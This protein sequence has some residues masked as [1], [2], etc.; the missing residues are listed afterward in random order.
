MGSIPMAQPAMNTLIKFGDGGSPEL[1]NI[2]ANV[3]DITGPSMSAAIVDVTSHST[4]VPWRQK[5]PTLLDSGSLTFP[6]FFVPSSD[7]PSGGIIGHNAISGIMKL[8]IDRGQNGIAGDPI[9]MQVVFPDVPATTYHL[10]GF[11]TN[12]VL[13]EAV[14]DVI[15]GDITLTLTGEPVLS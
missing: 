8:F 15:K 7:G 9:N 5:I 6:L 1:F 2:V 10:Q 13:H 4:G 3:G 12:F 14:A 11:I